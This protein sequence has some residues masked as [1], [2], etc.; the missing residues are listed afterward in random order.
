MTGSAEVKGKPIKLAI[1]NR[2]FWPVYPVIGEALLRFA[3]RAVKQNHSVS[4]IMQDH[5][6]IKAKLAEAQRGEG[7]RF[8]P[9]KAWTDSASGV[10][11]RAFDAVF[12]MLWV[13]GV[14]LWVRPERVYVSTDPPI[15][16]PFI[17]MIYCRLFGAE[18]IYHLQ[19]IHPE[20]TNIVVSVNKILFKV[21]LAIDAMVMRH[22]KYLITITEQ[23]AQEIKR[24]SAT[25]VPIY[26]LDNPAVSFDEIDIEKDKIPGFSFCGNAGRLQRIPLLLEAI[27]VY[28][29]QGGE[30]QFA[31]AGGGIY[32]ATLKDFSQKYPSFDYLG[33]VS[34]REAAQLNADYSWALLP[35]EDEVT[36][37]AF[38]SK[39]S[40]Y[41][42]SG[43]SILAVCGTQTSVAQWVV[44]NDLGIVVDPSV[45]SLVE[46]FHKIERGK[47]S[48][49]VSD[50]HRNALKEKLDFNFF[51][52]ELHKIVM[53]E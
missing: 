53:P 33:V 24:R 15:V 26:V 9:A 10:L 37:Y 47:F 3:E 23:M 7:V 30:L 14:L 1:I 48:F 50:Q 25:E 41:V 51:V 12:F 49:D 40:S 31:F 29:N 4:V 2:S 8:F 11:L 43:A 34:S 28:L 20:A 45:N 44:D 27:E 36:R 5:A 17:V 18:Y 52:D 22:A 13:L 38:P 39:S 42:F 6:G 46:A 35:I 16:V 32:S 21:L 19:D